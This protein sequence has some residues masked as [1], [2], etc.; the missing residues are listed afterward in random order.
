MKRLKEF[1]YFMVFIS[2]SLAGV[3]IFVLIPFADV[4]RRSF[5]TVMSG[6]F[7]GL[8][9]YKT[10]IS[11]QAFRLAVKNTLHFGCVAITRLVVIGLAA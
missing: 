3:L 8:N 1:G 10:V 5:M 2:M 11:N 4:V 9:N 7:A 6:E